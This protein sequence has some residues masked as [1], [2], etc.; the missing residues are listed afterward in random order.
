[1]KPDKGWTSPRVG[2]NPPN[3]GSGYA[4]ARAHKG[5]PPKLSAITAEKGSAVG[6]EAAHNYHRA[7]HKMKGY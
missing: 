1:M 5:T 6:N 2:P 3:A 7:K 4:H